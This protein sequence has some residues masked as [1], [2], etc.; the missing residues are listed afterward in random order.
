MIGVSSLGVLCPCQ[1]TLEYW[2]NIY[3]V[4]MRHEACALYFTNPLSFNPHNKPMSLN[5]FSSLKSEWIQRKNT[6]QMHTQCS[7]WHRVD[8]WFAWPSFAGTETRPQRSWIPS[9]QLH[10]QRRGKEDFH[11]GMSI[12]HL[13]SL[14]TESYKLLWLGLN[15]SRTL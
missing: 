11:P 15:W 9:L 12:T 8:H 13:H 4:P 3:W 10:S 2:K 7:A 1:R 5:I 6:C 14:S